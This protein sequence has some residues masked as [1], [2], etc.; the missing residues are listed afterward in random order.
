MARGIPFCADRNVRFPLYEGA[1]MRLWSHFSVELL[2][3]LILTPL[4]FGTTPRSQRVSDEGV[5]TVPPYGVVV[6]LGRGD[7]QMRML[8]DEVA[9]RLHDFTFAF[10]YDAD[11][12]RLY[13]VARREIWMDPSQ[14]SPIVRQVLAGYEGE[15]IAVRELD[16]VC[17]EVDRAVHAMPTADEVAMFRAEPA[18]ARRVDELARR[19]EETP[20]RLW[21]AMLWRGEHY[22]WELVNGEVPLVGE[23]WSALAANR[24]LMQCIAD[25]ERAFGERATEDAAWIHCGPLR[26]RQRGTRVEMRHR[27]SPADRRAALMPAARVE[28][29]AAMPSLFGALLAGGFDGK[30]EMLAG[31]AASVILVPEGLRAGDVAEHLAGEV[32]R[33]TGAQAA[34]VAAEEGRPR[35]GDQ[36][37]MVR[38]WE[39][40]VAVYTPMARAQCAPW[41]A[42]AGAQLPEDFYFWREHQRARHGDQGG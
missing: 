18:I 40:Y 31:F 37:W 35:R 33:V 42:L 39:R 12:R 21:E 9:P 4:V 27:V 29:D 17:H 7:A 6:L 41:D 25:A 3:D 1:R 15:H 24:T 28:G 2:P 34:V 13:P 19:L 5:C 10:V 16:R 23:L 22:R 30:T 8:L 32:R 14:L 20:L 38:H 11:Q 26:L 36:A